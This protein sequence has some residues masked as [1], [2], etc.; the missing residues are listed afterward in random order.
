MNEN[1]GYYICSIHP[2]Q[3]NGW[4]QSLSPRRAKLAGLF[5]EEELKAG[6]KLMPKQFRDNSHHGK[7]SK[8]ARRKMSRAVDYLT[9]I[10]P[11]QKYFHPGTGKS[12]DM[13]LNFITLTLPSEQ[14]H[15]DNEIKSDI[16]H[17][18]LV[19][20]RQ[21]WKVVNFIWRMEKQKNGN[22]HFHLITD[23]FI[24][25]NELRNQ[26]NRNCE[27]LGY[28]TRYRDNQTAWHNEGYRFNPKFSPKLSD[29]RQF[30]NYKEGVA[31]GWNNPNSTDVHGLRTIFNAT[32][33]LTKYITKSDQSDE[34]EGRLWG[35]SSNL[36]RIRGAE[37]F[38]EGSASDEITALIEDPRCKFYKGDYFFIITFK[39][40]LLYCGTFPICMQ[41]LETFIRA[42]FPEYRPP[43]LL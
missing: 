38:A 13:I 37:I 8:V 34:I 19:Q 22:T 32:A 17:P 33:Y 4:Y 9:H 36:V 26:W 7:I 21:K 24:P 18:F 11:K 20:C 12:G 14:I 30:H 40:T 23:R 28:V 41:E 2:S 31:C 3:I 15:S 39:N 10:V 6:R 29:A 27:K 5:D 43:L 42:H 16:L 1:N 35:C 25:W